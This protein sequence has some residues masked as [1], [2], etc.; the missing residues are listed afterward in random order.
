MKIRGVEKLKTTKKLISSIMLIFMCV[1]SLVINVPSTLAD[2]LLIADLSNNGQSVKITNTSTGIAS[3]A[4]TTNTPFD[5]AWYTSTGALNECNHNTTTINLT[6]SVNDYVIVTD[7][8]TAEVA[9]NSSYTDKTTTSTSTDPALKFITVVP[10]EDMKIANSCTDTVNGEVLLGYSTT[11]LPKTDY[12][13]YRDPS[14]HLAAVYKKDIPFLGWPPMIDTNSYSLFNVHSGEQNPLI[15]YTGL[16]FSNKYL[17][18]SDLAFPALFIKHAEPG[19][20]IHLINNTNNFSG[21]GV[22]AD[23]PTIAF[24]AKDYWK[25]GLYQTEVYPNYAGQFLS[26][27]ACVFGPGYT[28]ITVSPTAKSGVNFFSDY[29]SAISAGNLPGST[30]ISGNIANIAIQDLNNAV[31]STIRVIGEPLDTATGAHIA[32]QN[33]LTLTGATPLSFDLSYNSFLTQQGTFGTSWESNY[34]ASLNLDSSGSATINWSANRHNTFN[35]TGTTYTPKDQSIQYD[36]LTKSSTG[37]FTL[38]RKDNTT[39]NF[40]TTG[41]LTDIDTGHGQ[42]LNI[43]HDS[44]GRLL[45]I[46]EPISNKYI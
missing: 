11:N 30:A 36:N 21:F 38:T 22:T 14:S 32:N 10:G 24:T 13:Y 18:Y 6:L 5:Y 42:Q 39:Y 34:D 8:S 41:Q 15:M 3:I 28:D 37:N 19:Q 33:L 35:L 1:Y 2:G 29:F 23:D 45:K 9:I 7:T 16:E 44:N 4:S 26:D 40:D 17:K 31:N 27:G 25:L 20:T 46:T 43:S 12:V